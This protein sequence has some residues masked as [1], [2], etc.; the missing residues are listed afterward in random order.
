M[1]E[2]LIVTTEPVLEVSYQAIYDAVLHST[3]YDNGQPHRLYKIEQISVSALSAFFGRSWEV[4]SWRVF[5]G[6]QSG[7]LKGRWTV[8]KI[9]E[10]VADRLAENGRTI[11]GR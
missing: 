2:E 6:S 4:D 9:A 5:M 1:R 8:E 7:T 11:I 10:W 3:R